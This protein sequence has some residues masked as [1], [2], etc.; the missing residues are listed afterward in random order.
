MNNIVETSKAVKD[1]V[2]ESLAF[3]DLSQGH[4]S[5][6]YMMVHS[7]LMEAN[8]ED[9]SQCT[10]ISTQDLF[11]SIPVIGSDNVL[12]RNAACAKCNF[13]SYQT[14][15]MTILCKKIASNK[16]LKTTMNPENKNKWSDILDEYE[17]CTISIEENKD[18]KK[19]ILACDLNSKTDF[20]KNCSYGNPY[21]DLCNSY[22]GK[23]F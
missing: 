8:I 14:V 5:K 11:E 20:L 9:K 10:N 18:I 23:L 6:S 15:N 13:A 12:Y 4:V 21:Y 17:D 7:C 1:T 22:S 16:D 19:Y 3:I 2:C